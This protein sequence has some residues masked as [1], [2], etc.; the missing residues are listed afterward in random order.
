MKKI[1]LFALLLL[2]LTIF[3]QK[4]K[5]ETEAYKNAIEKHN[6]AADTT[7][8][9]FYYERGGIRQDNF[10][11]QGAIADYTKAIQ[12]KADNPKAYYNRGLAKL[13]LELFSDAITDFDKAIELNPKHAEAFNNRGISKYFLKNYVAAIKD[14]NAAIAINP[15][16][17]EAFNNRGISKIKQGLTN[18]GCEDLHQALKLG[19]KASKYGIEKYCGE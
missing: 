5:V 11:E 14:Y 9:Q 12:L 3:A 4:K 8:A 10:D 13:D 15:K 17:A 16:H 6:K 7:M 19:D 18:D 1:L 2:P